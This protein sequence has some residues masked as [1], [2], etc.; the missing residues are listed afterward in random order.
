MN[1]LSHCDPSSDASVLRKAM[2]GFGT[3]EA[4]IIGVL[5][6]RSSDQ[7]QQIL[8]KYQQAYGRVSFGGEVVGEGI[9]CGWRRL[10]ECG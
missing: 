3:D 10:R 9:C 6:H 2:K 4:A 7:R 8:L 1:P 5:A